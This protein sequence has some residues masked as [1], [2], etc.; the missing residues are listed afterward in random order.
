[1]KQ[2]DKENMDNQDDPIDFIK[3]LKPMEAKKSKAQVW[4]ELE[5][6]MEQP[7]PQQAKVRTLNLSKWSVAAS[8]VVLVSLAILSVMKFYTKNVAALPGEQ[9]IAYLPDGS[10][11]QLN[12]TSSLSYRPF[13]WRF[14]RE[15][16]LEG[17]GFFEVKEGEKFTV[18]SAKG[19]TSVLGTSFNIFARDN[20]YQVTCLTGRVKVANAKSEDEVIITTNQMAELNLSGKLNTKLNIDAKTALDWTEGKFIFTHEPLNKV[21]A[22]L[23]RRYGVEIKNI[24]NLNDPYTGYFNK[25]QD[26]EAVLNFVCKPFNIEYKKLPSGGYIIQ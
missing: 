19:Q 10:K 13:W 7:L 20:D 1:M 17:E 8:L 2:L 25:Q 3:N 5:K 11:V 15:V 24:T 9:S 23:S 21:L 14:D 22:E 26:I 6:M 4:A 18:V 16:T 12:S